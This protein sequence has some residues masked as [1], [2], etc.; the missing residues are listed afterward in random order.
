M[1]DRLAVRLSPSAP[2][3]EARAL[4]K[5]AAAGD[6]AGCRGV[7]DVAEPQVRT[8]LIRL[9]GEH[10][11]L[12]DLAV[13]AMDADPEDATA[14]ATRAFQLIDQGWQVRGDGRARNVAN[15][16]FEVFHRYLAE[17][18]QVVHAGLTRSAYDTGLWTAGLTTSRGLQMGLDHARY[19]YECLAAFDPHHVPGQSQLLQQLCPKWGGNWPEADEFAR[20]AMR[21]AP[22]GAHNAVLIV[23]YHLEKWLDQQRT[24]D[25]RSAPVRA[26]LE[27]AADRSVRHPAFRRTV[28]W[29][30]VVN[31]FAMAFSLT[32]DRAA[33]KQM[34]AML[35]PYASESPWVYQSGDVPTVF[36][37]SRARAYGL[38]GGLTGAADVL[39]VAAAPLI[40]YVT[41]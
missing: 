30:G 31:S 22:D 10:D 14:A 28:G 7:V 11:R 18:E 24:K 37:R 35:G 41:N 23:D 39:L 33:A 40:R 2:Y 36:R 25:L 38:S 3:P 4:F 8:R 9:L 15:R 21:A 6:W 17:A 20:T 32:G 27:E 34:F 13:R 12:G 16:K 29:V 26:D 5:A 19:R 1:L